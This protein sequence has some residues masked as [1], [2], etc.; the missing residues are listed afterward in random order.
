MKLKQINLT[1]Q[2][3]QDR[4]LLRVSTHGGLEYQAWL[5]RRIVQRLVP[6]LDQLYEL[7]TVQQ[8]PDAESRAAVRE[9]RQSNA[10][11]QANFTPEYETEG[12]APGHEG[13]PL[14]V[15]HVRLRRLEAGQ[16]L[17]VLSPEDGDG[18][19]L[20][21]NEVLL[22]ATRKLLIDTQQRAGWGLFE[23]SPVTAAAQPPAMPAERLN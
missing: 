16:Y 4:I 21:F 18:L 20:R 5:T 15:Y 11:Q 1:Y 6:A 17:L 22:H 14:L 19:Q 12:L 9:F 7:D 23:T 13:E 8:A 10:L 3:G 2:A